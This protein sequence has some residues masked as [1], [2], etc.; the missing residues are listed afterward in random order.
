M[1]FWFTCSSYTTMNLYKINKKDSTL[2]A[3]NDMDSNESMDAKS[4]TANHAFALL[5][6]WHY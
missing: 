3:K 2:Y 5:I 4:K 6:K 1:I